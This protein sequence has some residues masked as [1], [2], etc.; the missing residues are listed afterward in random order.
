MQDQYLGTFITDNVYTLQS[1]MTT[2]PGDVWQLAEEQ[3]L[4]PLVY[5]DRVEIT[6][7][8]GRISGPI[9]RPT[10]LSAG[11][12]ARINAATSTCSRT[13]RRAG[14]ATPS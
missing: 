4:E 13:R 6:D 11:R 10:W 5:T 8:R 9:S 7:P 2:Y 3:I 12:R 1:Q 14:S